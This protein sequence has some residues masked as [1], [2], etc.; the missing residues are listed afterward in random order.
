MLVSSLL[1][2][3]TAGLTVGSPLVKRSNLGWDFG[4]SEKVRGVN[5]GGWLVLEP[6]IVPSFFES[7]PST[8]I[9]EYTLGQQVDTATAT[10]MLQAHWGSWV[11]AADFQRLA[12][13][14]FNTVRIPIGF[15]AFDTF[16]TPYIKAGQEGYLDGA[17]D[18]A[19]SAGLKVWID[20]H[21]AP[22]SQNGFDNSGQRL[23]DSTPGWLTG[24]SYNQTL[25]VLNTIA[26]KYAQPAYQDTVVAIELVNEP[27]M[28]QLSGGMD[29]VKTYYYNGYGEVRAVSDTNVML[30][31][32][33][34]SPAEWNGVLT[35]SDNNAQNVVMDHHYY[36]AFTQDY[37]SMSPQ[38]HIDTVCTD[39]PSFTASRDKWLIVGEFTA[40]FDDCALWLNGR[41]KGA[42][43]DGT[44]PDST[45]VGDCSAR[46]TSSTWSDDMKQKTRAYLERQISAFEQQTLGWV[47]WN[48]KT[49]TATAWSL[50]GLDDLGLL[51]QPLDQ[52]LYGDVICSWD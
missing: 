29:A 15:W 47:F 22:L 43:Y 40:A 9:D 7:L 1:A 34:V 45:Y 11:S 25:S 46:N 5:I 13:L 20:L 23:D 14:G 26:Q 50:F 33:F 21:G 44:L 42:R 49:E 28:S 17:I 52:K 36:Q 18:W 30:H 37:V 10:S 51:P 27:L 24:D 39:A 12:A 35:P 41:N 38:T 32:G 16:D 48:F 3:A 19:R 8:V 31:D 2:L 4:G 6:F